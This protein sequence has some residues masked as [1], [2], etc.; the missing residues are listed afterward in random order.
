V[1]ERLVV[2]IIVVA[3]VIVLGSLARGHAR[4]SQS[5]LVEQLR[6]DPDLAGKA[7]ILTFY[8]PSC[9]ACDRQKIVLAELQA[10]R[11]GQLTVDLRDA[12]ANYDYARQF[13]LVIVPT[14]VVIRPDGAIG[15]INSGLI[16]RQALEAQLDAA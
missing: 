4:R 8:G 3:G 15:G 5:A 12:S 6:L 2:L 10:E 14:T 11:P 7:R 13:G 9:D 1:I 16:S